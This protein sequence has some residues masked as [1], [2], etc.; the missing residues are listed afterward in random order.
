M[1]LKS[2][3]IDM[4]KYPSIIVRVV[5][6]EGGIPGIEIMTNGYLN[7]HFS[8]MNFV[9]ITSTD[10]PWVGRQ[11]LPLSPDTD[12]PDIGVCIDGEEESGKALP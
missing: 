11:G 3:K 2:V 5:E 4:G 12:N 9:Y 1:K 10:K 6:N 8:S 7:A